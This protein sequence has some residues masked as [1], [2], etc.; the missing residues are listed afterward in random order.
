MFL[1]YARCRQF[2]S[3]ATTLFEYKIPGAAGDG[4]YARL[5]YAAVFVSEL[6][7]AISRVGEHLEQRRSR[8]TTATGTAMLISQTSNYARS[9]I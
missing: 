2:G 8:L 9:P 7:N 1:W 6:S 3:A 4:S 5:M